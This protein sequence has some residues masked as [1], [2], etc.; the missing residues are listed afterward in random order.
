[1][2]HCVR[3]IR[4][5]IT[6]CSSGKRI[7]L[8][9]S[10]YFSKRCKTPTCLSREGFRKQGVALALVFLPCERC[11]QSSASKIIPAFAGHNNEIDLSLPGSTIRTDGT[12]KSGGA[13]ITP[14]VER[15]HMVGRGLPAVGQISRRLRGPRWIQQESTE[16]CSRPPCDTGHSRFELQMDQRGK[17][18][19]TVVNGPCVR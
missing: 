3:T 6:S 4:V 8:Q 12:L 9:S 19:I 14:N 5:F 10:D 16:H 7:H 11:A 18:A 1:M 13:A 17:K 15:Y 2:S